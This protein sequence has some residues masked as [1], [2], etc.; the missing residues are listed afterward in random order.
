MTEI[1]VTGKSLVSVIGIP[2]FEISKAR[3]EQMLPVGKRELSPAR[4]FR[5]VPSY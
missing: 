1:L 3:F 2:K 5:T 4:L